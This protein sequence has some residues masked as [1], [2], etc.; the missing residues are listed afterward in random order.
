[1]LEVERG[2]EIQREPH[3]ASLEAG[4]RPVTRDVERERAADTEVGPEQ[5]AFETQREAAV[6]P[7]GDLRL[8]GNS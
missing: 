2:M 4:T 7:D 8:D 5:R 3:V 6:H 1:M